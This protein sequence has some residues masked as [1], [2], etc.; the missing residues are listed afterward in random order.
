MVVA[1]VKLEKQFGYVVTDTGVNRDHNAAKNVS[2][3]PD[4]VSPVLV[5]ASAFVDTQA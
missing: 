2:D 4:Y 3:W 5:D 1:P